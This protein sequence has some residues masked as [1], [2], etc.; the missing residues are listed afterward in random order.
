MS[1][2]ILNKKLEFGRRF[3]VIIIEKLYELVISQNKF[4]NE[5]NNQ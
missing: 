1:I 4:E 3:I 2:G 5:E